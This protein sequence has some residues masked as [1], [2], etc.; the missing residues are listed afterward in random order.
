MT[1]STCSESSQSKRDEDHDVEKCSGEDV[2]EPLDNKTS[3]ETGRTSPDKSPAKPTRCQQ[4]IL[5]LCGFLASF[6]A[7]G[8]GQAYGM[9]QLFHKEH[10]DKPTALLSNTEAKNRAAIASIGS[11]G[12]SGICLILGLCLVPSLCRSSV[13][14]SISV[15]SSLRKWPHT[16][17]WLSAAG[18]FVT[19][20]GYFCASYSSKLWHLGLTQG[21]LV[22][23]G[24][25]LM[26][27]PVMMVAPEYFS[28]KVRGKAM[29]FISAGAG[30]GGLVYSPLIRFMNDKYGIRVTLWFLGVFV[31]STGLLI[32][33][34]TPPPRPSTR[35][36]FLPKAVRKD[37]VLYLTILS[38]CTASLAALIPYGFGPEFSTLLGC[39]TKAAAIH[40][41]ALNAVGTP[42]RIGW[43]HIRD[44]IGSQNALILSSLLLAISN[45]MWVGAALTNGVA[46]WVAFLV[47]WGI[48]TSGYGTIIAPYV[49]DVFDS[50]VYFGILATVNVFR[51][52]GS[53][54]GNPLAGAILGRGSGGQEK[55]DYFKWLI[56]FNGVVLFVAV[57][58][59]VAARV[60]ISRRTG[61]KWIA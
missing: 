8:L 44:K 51:G 42:A 39:S 45:F 18:A 34:F 16:V 11:I 25:A 59:S 36:T 2:G 13:S 10:I 5:L 21:V 54:V 7:L 35:R 41:V 15:K 20:L 61:W 24:S 31:G 58:A 40:M 26:Y 9:F 17:T 32:A 48:G 43:G 4:T 56:T 46:L 49:L 47:V 60:L 28:E 37:P 52:I 14:A 33:C 22:G 19:F 6:Q 55:G 38:G 53:I 57:A 1:T 3:N 29:G 12:G 27:N 23:I 50:E 30:V